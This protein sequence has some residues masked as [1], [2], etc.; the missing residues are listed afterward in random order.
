MHQHPDL[1]MRYFK[2]GVARMVLEAQ[3]APL[4]VPIFLDGL[5]RVMPEDRRRPRWLPR[6]GARVRVGI[7]TAVDTGVGPF[8][9]LRERWD[10]IRAGRGGGGV[11]LGVLDPEGGL[12]EDAEAVALRVEAARMVRDMVATLRKEMGYPEQ[13]SVYELAE[14]WKKDHDVRGRSLVDGGLVED[15]HVRQE[16]KWRKKEHKP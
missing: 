8:A 1:F 2:W 16:G 13:D 10:A 14:T 4:L 12:R 3:P 5:Q 7:G 11:E 9:E 15:V 6:C